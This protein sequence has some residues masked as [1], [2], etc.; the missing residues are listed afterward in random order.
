MTKGKT[1]TVTHHNPLCLKIRNTKLANRFRMP[2]MEPYKSTIDTEDHL[3]TF[4]LAMHLQVVLEETMC[5]TFPS[6]P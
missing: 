2:A 4:E 6:N 3:S 1:T 5:K